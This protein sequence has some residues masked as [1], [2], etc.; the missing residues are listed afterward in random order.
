[1]V[2]LAIKGEKPPGGKGKGV[3]Q[4]N[5]GRNW[6]D[7]S[8]RCYTLPAKKGGR[9][10]A[11]PDPMAQ[12]GTGKMQGGAKRKSFRKDMVS[13]V[14]IS[15]PRHTGLKNVRDH[16][17]RPKLGEKRASKREGQYSPISGD[18][19]CN[20]MSGVRCPPTV[21][22]WGQKKEVGNGSRKVE[23]WDCFGGG[24]DTVGSM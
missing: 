3:V 24:K 5:D 2:R 1:M 22:K 8:G 4:S 10:Q 7:A 16:S 6:K 15:L 21:P 14:N 12:D 17:V 20:K 11:Y 19:R 13:L 23:W 9:R 18:K